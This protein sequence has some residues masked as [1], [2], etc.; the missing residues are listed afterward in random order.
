MVI[1]KSFQLACP[2]NKVKYANS[3][4]ANVFIKLLRSKGRDGL[5]KYRCN[6][7]RSIHLTSH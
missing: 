1:V 4:H 5:R 6:I 2:T 3:R 7:C